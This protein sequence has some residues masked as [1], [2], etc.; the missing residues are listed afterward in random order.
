MKK[1]MTIKWLAMCVAVT[2]LLGSCA[3]VPKN[4]EALKYDP[5]EIESTIKVNDA[6][7]VEER[8]YAKNDVYT[9]YVNEKRATFSVKNNMT[10]NVWYSN[11][12]VEYKDAMTDKQMSLIRVKYAS[13]LTN[14]K[15]ESNSYIGSVKDGTT[16]IKRIKGGGVIFEFFFEKIGIV[17]PIQV[18]LRNDGI[19]AS[20]INA[21]VKDM[22]DSKKGNYLTSVDLAPYFGLP[23][24]NDDGYMLVPDGCG[25]IM[26]WNDVALTSGIYRKPVYGRDVAVSLKD[27][28]YDADAIR[29]PVFGMQHT[30]SN[31]QGGDEAEAQTE[32]TNRIG[33]TAVITS[34]ASRAMLNAELGFG[35]NI[36]NRLYTE[37]IYRESA[38]LLVEKTNKVSNF[39]EQSH[40]VTPVQT[41]RYMLMEGENL[42][43]MD[44]AEEYRDYLT[45]DCGIKSSAKANSAPL[46]V[47]FFGGVMKQQ[48]VM[49]FPVNKVV[50]LTSFQDA[51]NIVKKLKSAGISE[52]IINY[53]QW[54]KDA[55][56]AG[57]QTSLKPEGE[58]GGNKGLQALISLCKS[59]NI[60]IFLDVNTTNMTKNTWGFSTR[61]DSTASLRMDPSL[62]YYY[63]PNTGKADTLNPWFLLRPSKML[64]VAKKLAGSSSK[65]DVTGLSSTVLG[66]TIY[67]DFA[68]DPVTR[69]YAELIWDDTMEALAGTKSQFLVNGGNAYSFDEATF[70]AN[71][72][73]SSSRYLNHSYSVPFYQIVLHGLIPMSTSAINYASNTRDAF[74]FAVETGSNLKWDWTA[75]NQDEL[76][77]TSFNHMTGTDYDK[78][79]DVAVEQYRDIQGFLKSV[80]NQSIVGHERISDDQVKVTWSNGI[81]VFVD[82]G[83]ATWSTM[84][85]NGKLSNH[86]ITW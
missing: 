59:E 67:S 84:D 76:V 15:A 51:Q 70:I 53:T 49:G 77:E 66:S 75:S 9:L 17:V 64:E 36:Y 10:G 46:V 5:P 11:P 28:R 65:Y 41:V 83:N 26:D 25:A 37:F 3:N 47:E 18:M 78:W 69:D 24:L 68:K 8:E 48:F 4:M 61:T 80:S 35:P 60:S 63:N 13:S 34:G 22:M 29:I 79:I 6:N 23:T 20:L 39:V 73:S 62:Q 58:L 86:N 38:E 55:T 40:T 56:G 81:V 21:E 14:E 31:T 30:V 74:L 42:S 33:Y 71:A 52:I 12:D 44:M 32:A 7:A 19:E 54:H 50:P 1:S 2:L 45:K 27:A 85:S 72:P 82:Y 43:Y 16:T 57:M